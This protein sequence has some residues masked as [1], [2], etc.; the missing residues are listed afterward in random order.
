LLKEYL[1]DGV[2]VSTPTGSTAYSLSAGGPLVAPTMEAMVVTPLCPHTMS[3]RPIVID[4]TERLT[5]HVGAARAEISVTTDGQEG[6]YILKGQHVVIRKSD[7]VTRLVVPDD[8]DFFNLLR[9]K[10]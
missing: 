2:I 3:I 1:A 5:I 4:S 7:K 9:E 8:Y 6:S 10:L